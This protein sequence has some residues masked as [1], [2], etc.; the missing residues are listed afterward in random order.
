M[1][2]KM[3]RMSTTVPIPMY[4]VV[5]F[6]GYQG[7]RARTVCGLE[8]L[9]CVYPDTASLTPRA[10][11]TPPRRAAV[12]ASQS[13]IARAVAPAARTGPGVRAMAPATSIGTG[14]EK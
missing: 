2:N 8:S 3:T 4:T 6:N 11:R 7:Q 14:G 1:S 10:G 9:P 12:R 5:P 13:R